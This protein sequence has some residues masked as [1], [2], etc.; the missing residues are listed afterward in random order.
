METEAY[1]LN[2]WK[3]EA[4]FKI[5]LQLDLFQQVRLNRHLPPIPRLPPKKRFSSLCWIKTS[6]QNNNV[7]M[8]LQPN[9]SYKNSF[10]C[11][12]HLE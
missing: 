8:F 6:E 5:L 2:L 9:Q 4:A 10:D 12:S 11:G 7:F 3:K 1:R